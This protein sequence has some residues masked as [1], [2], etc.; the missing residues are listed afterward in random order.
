MSSYLQQNSVLYRFSAGCPGKS[1]KD[2]RTTEEV[3]VEKALGANAGKWV[4]DLYPPGAMQAIESKQDEARSYHEFVTF[5]FGV[6]GEDPDASE[7]GDTAV[8][9]KKAKVK[10]KAIAGILPACLIMEYGDKMRQFKGEMEVLVAEF[11]KDPQQWVDWAM[12]EHNGT[13]EPKNYPG[14]T[15]DKVTG[16]ITFDPEVYRKKMA[17]KFYLT[18]EPLPVPDSQ[19]FTA[20]VSALLGQDAKSVDLRIADAQTEA[21]RELLRR[22]LEPVAAMAAKL[23][24]EPKK[25]KKTGLPKEDIIFRD[26]LITNISDIVKMVPKMNLSGDPGVERLAADV[27]ANLTRYT[28]KTLREDKAIRKQVADSA[29]DLVKRLSGYSL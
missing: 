9:G 19:H 4:A 2:R 26:T 22:I 5:P 6:K 29:A 21:K 23:V 10:G 8:D 25:D 13:F 15:R 27:E 12:K 20:E 24:E 1:R 7:N 16:A 11:L 3:K 14:C 18:W 17:A 28:A